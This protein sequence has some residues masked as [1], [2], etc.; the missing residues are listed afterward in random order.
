MRTENLALACTVVFALALAGK[1]LAQ[2]AL[3][4]P[5]ADPTPSNLTLVLEE[6]ATIP[7]SAAPPVAAARIISLEEIPDGSGRLAV[8][9]LN[10]K[11]WLIVDRQP[12]EFL[13]MADEFPHFVLEPGIG[14]GLAYLAFHPDFASNGLF[15]TAHSEGGEALTT[16]TPDMP[17]PGDTLL[18]GVVTEW[19]MNNPADNRFSGNHRELLRIGLQMTNHGMQQL[20]FNTTAQ[21]GDSDYGLLYIA[22]GESER[23]P[24]WTDAPQNL[25]MPHGKILRIDPQGNNSA[26]GQYGIP[27]NNPFAGQ[28]QALGEIFAYGMRN[29]H[30]F[31][32]DS[33]TGKMYVGMLGESTIEGLY[34][35]QAGDNLGW[36]L[37]EGPFLFDKTTPTQVYPLP[38]NDA[39]YGFVY[40]AA[41]Y[42]HGSGNAILAG[43]AYRGASLPVL[44]GKFILGDIRNGF[45]RFVE[46]ADLQR[47]GPPAEV[48]EF[49]LRDAAGNAV[50]MVD[51]AGGAPRVDLRFGTDLAGEE[52]YLMSKANGKIW[53]VT[54]AVMLPD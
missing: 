51:L 54:D 24:N 20:G 46:I 9:D 17:Y 25:S 43:M 38:A 39:E 10:G 14:S 22:M 47:G 36:N 45:P 29:P 32:W 35:L 3:P 7:A 53:Q 5:V 50:T 4:D 21:P 13:D 42:D 44:Q 28:P 52:I 41:M 40:P 34:E 48:F 6:F 18:Q 49:Q 8:A 11:A 1:P 19:K 37:R 23:V 26:N 31:V 12:V 30:R 27:A 2:T 16:L 15:Y 33:A